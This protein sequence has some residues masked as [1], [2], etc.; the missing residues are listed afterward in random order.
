MSLRLSPVILLMILPLAGCSALSA[1]GAASTPLEVFELRALAPEQPARRTRDVEVVVEEPVATG[2][3][4]TE[5][6][7]IRPAPLSAQYLPGVRW[8]DPA[9]AMLQTMLLRSLAETGA[10]N[11]VGRGPVGTRADYAVLGE[12]TDFQA[13]VAEGQG[14]QVRVRLMLRIVREGDAR[15]T[16]RRTFESV[17]PAADTDAATIVDAFDAALRS[18]LAD[19]V[20]WILDRV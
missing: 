8:A 14:A 7:M 4:A 16:A 19:M 13:E 1:L 20:P 15:V 11:S 9:P 17:A 18:M 6:I 2:A 5:R 10:F 12:L 3:L